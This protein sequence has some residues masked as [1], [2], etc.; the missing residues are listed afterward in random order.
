MEFKYYKII[1]QTDKA[2]YVEFSLHNEEVLKEIDLAAFDKKLWLPLSVCIIDKENKTID[3]KSLYYNKIIKNGIYCSFSA[4][5]NNAIT[6]DMIFK[7]I[8]I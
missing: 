8:K 2:V 3:I 7:Y 4:H 1:A 5:Q 6:N